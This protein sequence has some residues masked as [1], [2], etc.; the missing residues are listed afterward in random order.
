[1]VYF[2][3]CDP[4][5][6]FGFRTVPTF[7]RG[8]SPFSCF[9]LVVVTLFI[10]KRGQNRLKGN[11]SQAAFWREEG[12]GLHGSRDE[13]G[14]AWLAIAMG[15]AQK[16]HI[17]SWYIVEAAGAFPGKKSAITQLQVLDTTYAVTTIF[18]SSR[19]REL[20][21]E[22]IN[23]S[24]SILAPRR[25]ILEARK[26]DFGLSSRGFGLGIR[27]RLGI[28]GGS[29]SGAVERVSFVPLHVANERVLP[30]DS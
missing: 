14:E 16:C 6:T 13:S 9:L 5:S 29:F 10:V 12:F 22:D 17:R 8:L 3:R 21:F 4:F 25:S 26:L 28:G 30:K 7:L 27:K 11:L 2:R 19:F 23:S 1:M 24:L 20:L 15:A 18:F